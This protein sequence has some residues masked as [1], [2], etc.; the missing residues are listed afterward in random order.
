MKH[1][2]KII[3][4]VVISISIL[5][6]DDKTPTSNPKL[7]VVENVSIILNEDVAT[8]SYKYSEKNLEPEGKTTF[9]WYRADNKQGGNEIAIEGATHEYYSYSDADNEKHLAFEVVPTQQDGLKGEAVK[10]NYSEAI[11]PGN[12]STISKDRITLYS[13]SGKEII[14]I[15][16]YKVISSLLPLQKDVEKHKELWAQILKVVPED[17]LHRINQFLVYAGSYDEN[18]RFRDV[19]GYVVQTNAYLSKWQFGVAIDYSY[20]IP[21]DDHSYGLNNTIVHEFGHI[22]TLNETQLD[23]IKKKSECTTYHPGEGCAKPDSYLYNL[24]KKY[25]TYIP[26]ENSAQK[27]YEEYEDQFVSMYAATNAPEDIAETFRYFVLAKIPESTTP[28]YNKKILDLNKS[29][30]LQ[31]IRSYIRTHIKK[32]SIYSFRKSPLRL[33]DFR[34]CGTTKFMKDKYPLRD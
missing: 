4:L 18:S 31:N 23:P 2:W 29:Q 30:E 15:K 16:D 22:I 26:V 3:G 34:G 12:L 33:G 28:I 19:L 1:F 5:N 8:G 9:Q 11:V 6:C 27:N 14:K 21:F 17:Y 7:P 20:S 13:V 24:Y 32:S 25:W 10:S